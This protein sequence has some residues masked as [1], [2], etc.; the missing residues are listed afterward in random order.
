M[1]FRKKNKMVGNRKAGNRQQQHSDQYMLRASP[2]G[3]MCMGPP[4][5]KQ[6]VVRTWRIRC[7]VA[8]NAAS[9]T[10]TSA[11]LG[12]LLGIIATSATTSVRFTQAFRLR[13]VHQWSW[14]GTIGTTVDIS[15]KLSDTATA[16]G[17]GGPPCTIADS[18]ASVEKPAYVG[19]VLPEDSIF[20]RWQNSSST[21]SFLTYYSPQQSVMDLI[22]D[23]FIDDLGTLPAGPAIAGAVLG[24]IYHQN[25]ATLTVV[26]PLNGI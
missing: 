16:G 25:V 21:N 9:Q 1:S 20:A 12:A 19:L 26:Q 5:Y 17:Q 7:D 22:F 13:S 11:Q 8:A 6:Q 18:S 4:T 23:F 15:I 10:L 3:G 2:K 24:T 14:T